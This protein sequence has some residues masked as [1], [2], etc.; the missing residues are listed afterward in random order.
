MPVA[1]HAFIRSGLSNHGFLPT[2]RYGTPAEFQFLVNAFHEAGIGV[3]ID[4]V[5]AHFP[6]D[7]LGAGAV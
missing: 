7:D 6:R 5:P 1:E 4:W 2:S 3:L